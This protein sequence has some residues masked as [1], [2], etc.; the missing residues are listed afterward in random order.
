MEVGGDGMGRGNGRTK[1]HCLNWKLGKPRSTA[2]NGN[3]I[4]YTHSEISLS[5]SLSLSVCL[6]VC[7]S[8]TPLLFPHESFPFFVTIPLPLCV[9]VQ[10][11]VCSG[12][13]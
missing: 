12:D 9:L 4:L 1:E 13:S 6:S 5:V 7:L 8:L 11:T 10:V 2:S 3:V